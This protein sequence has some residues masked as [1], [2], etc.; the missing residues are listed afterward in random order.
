ML[1]DGLAK[2]LGSELE[3]MGLSVLDVNAGAVVWI[4]NVIVDRTGVAGVV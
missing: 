2:M 4:S 1:D 3:L